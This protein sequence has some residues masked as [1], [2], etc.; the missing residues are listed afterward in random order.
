MSVLYERII[1]F[2][3][4]F[5]RRS[6]T[7]TNSSLKPCSTIS[8]MIIKLSSVDWPEDRKIVL[9][10][11]EAERLFQLDSNSF[12]VLL[13]IPEMVNGNFECFLVLSSFS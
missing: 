5:S 13:R 11:D 3:S 8:E 12:S 1:A 9:F 6:R 7:D 2:V 10:V 4:S